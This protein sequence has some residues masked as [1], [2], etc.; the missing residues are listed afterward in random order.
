[1]NIIKEVASK[2]ENKQEEELPSQ[3]NLDESPIPFMSSE[4]EVM[5]QPQIDVDALAKTHLRLNGG[6]QHKSSFQ[7][8]PSPPIALPRKLKPDPN[9][10]ADCTIDVDAANEA[11]QQSLDDVEQEVIGIEPQMMQPEEPHIIRE[12][13]RS[14]DVPSK[15][16]KRPSE[17]G[18]EDDQEFN[19]CCEGCLYYTIRCCDFFTFV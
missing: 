15:E 2:H 11:G 9:E 18:S 13:P 3:D 19:G 5:E 12:Q 1:M 4:E 14:T 17:F 6:G 10:N 7:P 16:N 8:L